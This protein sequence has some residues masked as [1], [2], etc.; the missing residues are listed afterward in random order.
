V[1]HP[2]YLLIPVKKVVTGSTGCSGGATLLLVDS[3]EIAHLWQH[4]SAELIRHYW[5]GGGGGGG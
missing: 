1:V 2:C 5:G 4:P 3:G